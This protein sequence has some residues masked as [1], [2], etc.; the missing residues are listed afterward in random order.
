VPHTIVTFHAHPDDEAI[1]TGGV[2]ARYS[3]EGNRVVLVVATRGEHGEVAD[4]VLEP[5][6][7]LWQRRVAETERAAEIL[8]VQRVEFLGY[9]DSGMMG[10]PT[11]DIPDA[12]WSADVDE[13][14]RRLAAIL[15]EE[16][17]DVLTVYDD[18]GGY[19][20]PDHIQVHRVGVRGAELARTPV[21]YES[22]MNRDHIVRLLRERQSEIPDGVERPN[23]DDFGEFGTPE[24]LITTTV[25]VRD[26]VDQKRAAMAAHQS[27]IDENHFFLMMPADAFREAFGHEWFIRRDASAGLHEDSLLEAVPHPQAR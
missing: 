20:H 10:E 23:P 9:H 5:G 8:G 14:A 22:T 17:A 11:N 16:R 24:T 6:E 25:D 3:A 12:F 26:F 21:V 13:A 1:A 27:Q 19:G 7:E 4:G 2:M 15:E 18:H